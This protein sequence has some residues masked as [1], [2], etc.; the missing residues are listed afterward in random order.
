MRFRQS[1]SANYLAHRRQDRVRP[2]RTNRAWSFLTKSGFLKTK[3][4]RPT[5]D[6][7]QSREAAQFTGVELIDKPV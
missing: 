3:D 7:A 4:A 5:Y 6:W 1:G 2:K